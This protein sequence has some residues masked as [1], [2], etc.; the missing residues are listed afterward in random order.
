MKRRLWR[1][2]WFILAVMVAVFFGVTSTKVVLAGTDVQLDKIL[3][4]GLDGLV[5]YFAWL[6]EVLELIW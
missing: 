2:K 5:A 3:K 1:N 4:S 6:I